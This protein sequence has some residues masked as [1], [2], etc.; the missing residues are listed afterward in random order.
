[1]VMC[2]ISSLLLN[3]GASLLPCP[4]KS[5]F[6]E[7]MN[8]CLD[9]KKKCIRWIEVTAPITIKSLNQVKIIIP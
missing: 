1:M 5:Q 2:P 7:A 4:I 3:W 9:L 6:S 8:L